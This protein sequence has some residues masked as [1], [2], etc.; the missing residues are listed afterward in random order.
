[1][2]SLYKFS[3]NQL[4][5]VLKDYHPDRVLTLVYQSLALATMVFFTYKES[6]INTR[7]RNMSGYILFFLA[8][9]TLVLVSMLALYIFLL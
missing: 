8:T 3:N 9:L 1:M 2:D 5:V 6:K 7:R 4:I